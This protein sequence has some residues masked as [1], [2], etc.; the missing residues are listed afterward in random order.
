MGSFP[1]LWGL[2]FVLHRIAI[3]NQDVDVA[4]RAAIRWDNAISL[5]QGSVAGSQIYL[6][7]V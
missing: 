4:H 1:A 5:S 3:I 6:Q 7:L 2:K